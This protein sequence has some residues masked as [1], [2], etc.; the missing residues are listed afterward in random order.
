MCE[1]NVLP[2]AMQLTNICGNVMVSNSSLSTRHQLPSRLLAWMVVFPDTMKPQSVDLL[3]FEEWF[4]NYVLLMLMNE[5][6]N[7]Y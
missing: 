1:L 3:C 4:I 2:L 5:F 6:V 7:E